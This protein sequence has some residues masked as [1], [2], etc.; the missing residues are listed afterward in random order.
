MSDLWGA[1]PEVRLT[2][3]GCDEKL[4]LDPHAGVGRC[5]RC[6]R[7]LGADDVRL[8]MQ[9]AVSTA[10]SPLGMLE[11]VVC[12]P[13][14]AEYAPTVLDRLEAGDTSGLDVD[15]SPPSG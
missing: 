12:R 13:C 15:D 3:A 5:M 8:R 10:A 2:L 14:I 11:V 1:A 6:R 7:K 4:V 9:L